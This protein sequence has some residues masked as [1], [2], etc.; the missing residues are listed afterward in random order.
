[1]TVNNGT[2]E[3]A[4]NA[5][6]VNMVVAGHAK[7]FCAMEDGDATAY[8]WPMS[9]EATGVSVRDLPCAGSSSGSEPRS[10]HG[11]SPEGSHK[12]GVGGAHAEGR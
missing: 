7:A 3:Y 11:R 8:D 6:T 12:S 4:V 10:A 2:K 5:L 1:M 9:F